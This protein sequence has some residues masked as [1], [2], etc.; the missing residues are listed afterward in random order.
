VLGVDPV[1]FGLAIRARR[2][3]RGWRQ[4]DLASASGI[5]ASTVCRIER[6]DIGAIAYGTLEAVC[7]T[8][9]VRL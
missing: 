1:R 4:V 5:S 9:G 6:A 2:R 7:R 8:L 3:A